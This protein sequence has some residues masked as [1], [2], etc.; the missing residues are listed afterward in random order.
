MRYSKCGHCGDDMGHT[1]ITLKHRCWQAPRRYVRITMADNYG[2][3]YR[4]QVGPI[5]AVKLS[6]KVN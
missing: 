6:E 2:H 4:K 5:E 1:Q 3:L